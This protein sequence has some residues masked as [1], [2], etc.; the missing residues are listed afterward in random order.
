VDAGLGIG[1]IWLSFEQ[2]GAFLGVVG[3]VFLGI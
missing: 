2:F 1:A 3:S